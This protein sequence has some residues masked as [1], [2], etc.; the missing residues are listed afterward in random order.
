MEIR[1]HPILHIWTVFACTR[2][3]H[4]GS[5]GCLGMCPAGKERDLG[6]DWVALEHE[7][8]HGHGGE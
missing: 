5:E 8:R 1:L 4:G 7:Y 6:R 3:R 2:V